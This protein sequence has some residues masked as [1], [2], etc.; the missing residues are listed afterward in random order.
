LSELSQLLGLCCKQ[1]ITEEVDTVFKILDK[2]SKGYLLEKD[3][4]D[5]LK[6]PSQMLIS[7]VFINYRDIFLPFATLAKKI[8]KFST[9]QLLDAFK[10]PGRQQITFA[11]LERMIGTFLNFQL[12]DD[13]VTMLKSHIGSIGGSYDGTLDM[14]SFEKIMMA[15]LEETIRV[16][17][18]VMDM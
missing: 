3:F 11:G 14:M 13:E 5:I 10:E 18:D 15:D 9:Q 16:N 7:R 12:T 8:N 4:E 17:K 2:E 1:V 6:N